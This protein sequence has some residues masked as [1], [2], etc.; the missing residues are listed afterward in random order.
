VT[1]PD[2]S[3]SRGRNPKLDLVNYYLAVADGALRGVADRPMILKR[4][5]KGIDAEA[6]FQKRAPRNDRTGSTSPSCVRD[7]ERRPRRPCCTTRR[8]GVG[9]QP[10][11]RG[12]QPASGARR[13]LD[14]P[15]ELRID[16][17]PMPGV[18]WPQILDVAQVVAGP[19]GPRA[20][21]LAEDLGVA[22]L[23]HLR[24][25]RAAVA[26]RRCGWPPRRWPARSSAGHPELAT[27]HWW[28]EDRRGCSSTS[29]R[30]RRTAR[31]PR[32]IR[33]GRRRTPGCRCR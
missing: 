3:S 12:P 2:K 22:R 21:G 9:G 1:H 5:V 25:D 23:P 4:F 17:D 19:R 10:R 24:P 16:L 27:S 14:H 28:K 30:T 32:P 29:T 18:G 11:L 33:C 8:S 7:R 15:D 13:D 6:I 20:D 31:W 26:F